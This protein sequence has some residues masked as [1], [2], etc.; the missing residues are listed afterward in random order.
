MIHAL[1]TLPGY[2]DS[3][4]DGFKT[5]EVRK[6]DRPFTVDD[7][8]VLQEWQADEGKYTGREW[9]GVITYM[10]TDPAYVK[11]GYCILGIKEKK[12]GTKSE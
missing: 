9:H 12:S 3:V 5:F 2:F 4:Q 7:S 8:I 10:L 11:K 1:K 6:H